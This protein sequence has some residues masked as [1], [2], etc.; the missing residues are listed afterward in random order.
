VIKLRKIKWDGK[1]PHMNKAIKFVPVPSRY[2][3]EWRYSSTTLD[4]GTRER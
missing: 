3:G 1:V 2:M 4:L